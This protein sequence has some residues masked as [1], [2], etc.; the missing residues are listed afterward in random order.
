[1]LVYALQRRTA[2]LQSDPFSNAVSGISARGVLAHSHWLEGAAPTL[3]GSL[4]RA[5]KES[6]W[7]RTEGVN[8]RESDLGAKML[9]SHWAS[10]CPMA[11]HIRV[12]R[13]IDRSV[14]MFHCCHE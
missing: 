4:R 3:L 6:V 1:M 13:C 2:R 11:H 5:S 7:P 12:P 14:G 8:F 9:S 10:H